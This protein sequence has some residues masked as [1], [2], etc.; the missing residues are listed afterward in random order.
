MN[1]DI[2][3]SITEQLKDLPEKALDAVHFLIENIDFVEKLSQGEK[4]TKD[5]YKKI[6]EKANKN[7]DYILKILIIYKYMKDYGEKPPIE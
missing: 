4:I 3:N 7:E 6:M 5:E 2:F 1:D